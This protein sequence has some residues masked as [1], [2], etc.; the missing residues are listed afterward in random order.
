MT[1]WTICMDD[2]FAV[3]GNQL[4]LTMDPTSEVYDMIL[5]AK[6]EYP[7]LRSAGSNEISIWKIRS[8]V[9][10]LPPKHNYQLGRSELSDASG[11][12]V[13]HDRGPR[14][15]HSL[16]KLVE[17]LRSVGLHDSLLKVSHQDRGSSLAS[18]KDPDGRIQAIVLCPPLGV[19]M[20]PFPPVALT[21]VVL[22]RKRKNK[23]SD[24][25]ARR[26]RQVVQSTT[27]S[28]AP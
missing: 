28:R 11:N 7:A 6:N 13:Q 24:E 14:S 4:R 17:H 2:R 21:N 26:D 3:H 9:P 5:A 20:R 15:A 19:S 16:D 1:I 22:E 25:V 10:I 12:A 27:V 23:S 8:P 18:K